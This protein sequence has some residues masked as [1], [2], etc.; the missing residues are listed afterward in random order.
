MKLKQLGSSNKST[1]DNLV[2]LINVVF[3]M[4]I[5]FMIA[6]QIRAS[7]AVSIMPPDSLSDTK[8]TE[9]PAKIVMSTLQGLYL[10]SEKI[11]QTELS[12]ALKQLYLHYEFKDDFMVQISADFDLPVSR[13]QQVMNEIEKAGLTRVFLVTKLKKAS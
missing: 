13:L 3:L 11:N 10:N 12:S 2:P 7:D 9:S 8:Q 4:L 5:F 1:D 6:G